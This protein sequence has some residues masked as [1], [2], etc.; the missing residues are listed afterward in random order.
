MALMHFKVSKRKA[1]STDY[2]SD[3]KF[4]KIE[5]P[6]FLFL[7]W[8]PVLCPG[9]VCTNS[10]QH[11]AK[12]KQKQKQK[13]WCGPE[14]KENWREKWRQRARETG[15]VAPGEGSR[16]MTTWGTPTKT[17]ATPVLQVWQKHKWFWVSEQPR[18]EHQFLWPLEKH[19]GFVRHR[20]RPFD[21]WEVDF[22]SVKDHELL[23]AP[24]ST[25]R[26]PA[27][28]LRC[29]YI[30]C[31]QPTMNGGGSGV[32]KPNKMR[33]W[34]G[35]WLEERHWFVQK[36]FLSNLTLQIFSLARLHIFST[37]SYGPH[38]F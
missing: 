29:S 26:G 34:L 33:N 12:S 8:K 16:K 19:E 36:A 22:D 38:A 3:F 13:F 2:L 32:L 7:C 1:T 9:F 37:K 25:C 31:R 24:E 35:E 5:L 23:P 14:K 20:G 21:D 27:R 11:L 17:E 28:A 18:R 6:S 30:C 15:V 10:S 4:S